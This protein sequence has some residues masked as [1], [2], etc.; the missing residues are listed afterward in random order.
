MELSLWQLSPEVPMR[1]QASTEEGTGLLLSQE[2]LH[3]Y[4]QMLE[5]W[6]YEDLT[7]ETYVF[8]VHVYKTSERTLG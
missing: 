8:F 5:S 3:I 1:G 2:H 7:L 6:G 4:R